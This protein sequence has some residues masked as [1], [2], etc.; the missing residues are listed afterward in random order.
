MRVLVGYF[1]KKLIHDVNIITFPTGRVK[2][3]V[4]LTSKLVSASVYF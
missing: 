1:S 2:Y 3:F 4:I